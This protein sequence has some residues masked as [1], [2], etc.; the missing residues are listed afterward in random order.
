MKLCC[1]VGDFAQLE[2]QKDRQMQLEHKEETPM[3]SGLQWLRREEQMLQNSRDWTT[4]EGNCFMDRGD[5][6]LF[7]EPLLGMGSKVTPT[8]LKLCRKLTSALLRGQLSLLML[9]GS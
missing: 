6:G 9:K 1:S 8:F 2:R 3:L 5:K 4:K 7:C